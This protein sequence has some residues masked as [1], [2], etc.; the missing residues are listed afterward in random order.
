MTKRIISCLIAIAMA[1]AVAVSCAGCA[2]KEDKAP[3]TGEVINVYNWGEYIANGDD[4]SM[5]VIA[6]FTKR[7]GIEVNYTNFASNEEMYAKISS[8]SADYDVIIPSDYMIEKMIKEDMLEPLDMDNIPNFSLID[9]N[10]KD[11]PYD[12]GNK[13][14]VPYTWGTVGIFYNKTMVD[15]ADVAEQSWDLLWNEKYAG[16]ILMFDNQRDAF[17]IALSKLG[18]SMNS[19]DPGQWQE[20]YELLCEQKPLV[21][22]YVMDQIFDKMANE[23]AAVAPYY[24]GDARIMVGENENIGF[25]VP[26]EGTNLFVDAMCIPKGSAHKEAAEKFINFMCETDIALE[27]IEYICY[28]TPQME[29]YK[30]LDEDVRNNPDYYPPQE[31][32]DK[33][34]VYTDLP[35]DIYEQMNELWI[36][37][38]TQK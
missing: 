19:T 14:S 5:D 35:T 30:L 4:G 36:Q 7:T 17:G 9:P 33:C 16:D 15:E 20:A 29:T 32:L 28:S 23:E 37:L 34:E 2:K 8:G 27:N 18:Y 22:A 3:L 21:Q 24:A 12:P 11:L 38:K 13:Y 25:Y 6:E 1:A 10:Y 31:I 26:K